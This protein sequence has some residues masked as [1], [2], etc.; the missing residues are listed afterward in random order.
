MNGDKTPLIKHKF[1]MSARL[2]TQDELTDQYAQTLPLL[3]TPQDQEWL[4]LAFAQLLAYKF[5]DFDSLQEV[6]TQ[7]C[8]LS[9][10]SAKSWLLYIQL[11]KVSCQTLEVRKVYTRAMKYC[12]EIQR[13]G[14]EWH[15]FELLFGDQKSIGICEQALVKKAPIVST[16]E[17]PADGGKQKV[18]VFCRNLHR[19]LT[20]EVFS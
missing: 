6:M 20:D 15:Q 7:Y 18:T 16:E 10:D 11:V 2:C 4:M 14:K 5:H 19:N 3:S 13:I 9:Q 1:E 8:R 17:A 12:A